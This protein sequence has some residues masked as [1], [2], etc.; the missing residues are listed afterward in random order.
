MLAVGSHRHSGQ[1][2]WGENP[3]LTCVLGLSRYDEAP[4]HRCACRTVAHRD[5]AWWAR[6]GEE[7]KVPSHSI[8]AGVPINLLM[9]LVT[10][11]VKSKIF[12]PQCSKSLIWT[13]VFCHLH[14]RVISSPSPCSLP[15]SKSNCINPVRHISYLTRRTRICMDAKFIQ[16]LSSNLQR[17][18]VRRILAI[19]QHLLQKKHTK[20]Q[21]TS[22]FL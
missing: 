9:L 7:R 1:I 14:N 8:Q 13:E 15:P 2:N 21:K 3:K 12:V 6:G 11:S 18:M 19:E 16:K 5:A 22:T 20:N 10:A 17:K 4:S